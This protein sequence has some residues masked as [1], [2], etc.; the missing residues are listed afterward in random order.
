MVRK[1]L[2]RTP[3]RATNCRMSRMSY[4]GRWP[5]REGERSFF[6]S[7]KEINVG[8]VGTTER[9]ER[10]QPTEREDSFVCVLRSQVTERDNF[11]CRPAE[12]IK[13]TD[14]GKKNIAPVQKFRWSIGV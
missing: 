9:R 7:E 10:E 14:E 13:S 2:T 1:A 4:L 3:N 6:G 8:G 11:T 12:S 5:K